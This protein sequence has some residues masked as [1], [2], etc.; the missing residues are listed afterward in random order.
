MILRAKIRPGRLYAVS[1]QDLRRKSRTF[2]D[3]SA[4][5]VKFLKVVP[6]VFWR[7]VLIWCG[8]STLAQ[9]KLTKFGA[10]DF[11]F[12]Y[13]RKFA[14]NRKS[15]RKKF[16]KIHLVCNPQVNSCIIREIWFLDVVIYS[17]RL[18]YSC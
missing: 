11:I 13:W 6:Q 18:P 10:C 9:N 7:R 15:W 12:S 16:V 1:S 3:F 14:F 8:I 5:T 17:L 4:D 2:T